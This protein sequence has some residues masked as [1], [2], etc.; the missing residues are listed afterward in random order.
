[1]VVTLNGKITSRRELKVEL[2]DALGPGAVRAILLQEPA[3][4]PGARLGTGRRPGR[5][6]E[7]P[8]FGLWADRT[9]LRNAASFA[10]KLRERLEGRGDRRR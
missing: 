6:L 2:P 1:M 7:H 3:D 4:L 10:S 8:A 9:D 5:Q